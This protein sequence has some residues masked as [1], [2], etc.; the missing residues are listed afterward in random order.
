MYAIIVSQLWVRLS[1]LIIMF[2][3]N[4]VSLEKLPSIPTQT[5]WVFCGTFVPFGQDSF[6]FIWQSNIGKTLWQGIEVDRILGNQYFRI[7]AGIDGLCTHYVPRQVHRW[8]KRLYS[9]IGLLQQTVTWYKIIHAR[10]QV[11]PALGNPKQRNFKLDCS[12][13]LCLEAVTDSFGLQYGGILYHVIV[14]QK[15]PISL[16]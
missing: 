15:R 2:V 11:I 9:A 8:E 13:S 1:K 16:L 4:I 5:H 6:M 14:C 10:G 7:K 12:K 3:D